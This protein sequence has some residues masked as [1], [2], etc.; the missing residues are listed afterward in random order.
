MAFAEKQ[1]MRWPGVDQAALAQE[2]FEA[3]DDRRKRY[4]ESDLAKL[5]AMVANLEQRR[6]DRPKTDGGRPERFMTI[7][8]MEELGERIAVPYTVFGYH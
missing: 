1:A 7:A 4:G 5:E 8:D 6:A 3:I 2:H